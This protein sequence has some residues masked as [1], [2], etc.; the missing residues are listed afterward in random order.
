M[1]E[2]KQQFIYT[3]EAVEPEKAMSRDKWT[4]HDRETYRLYLEHLEREAQ[5]RCIVLV[6]RAQ[7]GTGPARDYRVGGRGRG[8]ASDG[9]RSVRLPR[10]RAG[11]AASVPGGVFKERSLTRKWRG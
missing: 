4:E 9:E 11:A 1:S 6:G 3:L 5:S 2:G 7:D 8:A 10:V